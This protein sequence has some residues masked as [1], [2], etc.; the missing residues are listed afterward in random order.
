MAIDEVDLAA[1]TRKHD[2]PA[3][4]VVPS[5]PRTLYP[6]SLEQ[7]IEIC[8]TRKPSEKIHAAG[9]HWALS[10]AAISDSVFV[11][12]HDPNNKHQAMDRTLYNVV[13]KCLNKQF[14]AQLAQRQIPQFELSV[15]E[16][17]G[18]YP[19]HV[20]TGKRVY[21][22]YAELDAGD[23]D[24]QS[25][26]V[27]LASIGNNSYFGP[28]GFKTLGG[29]G[30][31]TVFGALTTGTHGGDY[32]KPPI[33]DAVMAIHLVADGGKH[34]WI[35]PETLTAMGTPL[36]DDALLHAE[37]D[38]YGGSDNFEVIRDDNI[39]DSV[40]ISAGRFGIVYSMVIA[41][42]RQYCM[43][44]ERRLKRQD[45]TYITWQDIK[46][47]ISDRVSLLYTQT[48]SP[49][50]PPLPPNSPWYPPTPHLPNRFLQV[51]ISVTPHENFTKNLAGV[52]KR[53]NVLPRLLKPGTLEPAGRLERG[54][55]MAG[56]S[57]AYSPDP[58]DPGKAQP[59]SFLERACSNGDFMIGVLEAVCTE[60]DDFIKSNGAVVG[61]AILAA[62]LLGAGGLLALLAA[63]AVIL[64][65]LLV[66]LAL[67][68][69]AVGG[70]KTRFGQVMNDVRNT[71]LNR[72]DPQE[73]AAGL[74]TWHLIA[75]K[76]FESQQ[77]NADFEAISYA[78]MDGHDY[79]DKTCNINVDSIEVF[80][81]S[82]DPMLIAY[83]DAILAFE[84][85]QEV[86]VSKAFVG[87]ISL[88]FTS[89]TR[90]L[91]G[92]QQQ[93]FPLTCAVEISGLRDVSGV[94]ELID[95]ATMLA[96]N[97]N[98]KG[99]LHWGQRNESLRAHVQERFGDTLAD[100]SG[101]LR[102]WR[103]ALSRITQHGK[104]DG[105]SSA[106]T[107]RTGLEVVTPIIGNLSASSTDPFQPITIDWDCD[108]NPPA[109]Q[110]NLEV[111]SPSGNWAGENAFGG[112][113]K[114]LTVGRNQ[115]GRLEVLYVG[116][117]DK[118]YH[119]WQDAPSNGWAGEAAFGGSAKQLTVGRNQDGRLE[120]FYVGTD[121]KLYHNWQDAPSG[122]WVGEN[123]FGGSA[124][125]LTVGMNQDGRLEVFYVGTDNKLYHNWQD[126]RN[127]A[128]SSFVALPLVGQQQV[129]ANQSGLHSVSLV[130]AIDL[131]GERR[132]AA[133][134]VGVTIA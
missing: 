15:Q 116:A 102:T 132:E 97:N 66:F 109:T 69:A 41:A 19:I 73:R 53:W 58:N 33:A 117:D 2:D 38:Q 101:N 114:Q 59:T 133:Q 43:H 47:Q 90:A 21:Q 22:L 27:H 100:Q 61:P 8:S 28:W 49:V 25:L 6:Q 125:Q 96:L 55:P 67:L 35:E 34:Y 62:T 20:E 70:G 113:A 12:T 104:L 18:L 32:L 3:K 126:T 7:L 76:V 80:F 23:N 88:R 24:P 5:A 4:P 129:T 127:G 134:Q 89:S 77:G 11:E 13:W 93:R 81:D 83:I 99:I 85:W 108:Q 10:E 118:L 130:A 105:F 84:I 1:W 75:F 51:A 106:F 68:R 46:G 86:N 63:L 71:L 87:Y 65:I 103:D 128:Q 110:I 64:A 29:A 44:Q 45:E 123:A 95:F 37:Y 119:N 31:Q 54:G 57:S 72:A 17:D 39:F 122:D 131:A 124:K 50:P 94:T 74:F 120:V 14:I 56:N 26:A 92:Q 60:L 36:T 111:I 40:L 52:T 48:D 78:V 79:F 82:T 115:D 42:V 30:G 16:D 9:S 107:R 121:D 112:S 98:F 91:I